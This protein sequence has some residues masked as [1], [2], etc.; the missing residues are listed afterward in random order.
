MDL[1]EIT[2]W[3]RAERLAVAD[4]LDALDDQPAPWRSSIRVRACSSA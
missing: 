2:M 4:R 3:T 1:D